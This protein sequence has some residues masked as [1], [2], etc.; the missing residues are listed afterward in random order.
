MYYVSSAVVVFALG[1]WIIYHLLIHIFYNQIDEGLL[2]EKLLIEEQLNQSS[3]VPEYYTHIGHDIRVLKYN[4]YVKPFYSLK[5]TLIN[6]PTIN[7]DM[8]FRYLHVLDNTLKNGYD[9]SIMHPINETRNMV[10]SIF[11]VMLIMLLLLL[12]ILIF[13]NYLI[14]KK[15]WLPFYET[16]R[17]IS[18]YNIRNKSLMKFNSSGISEFNLLNSVLTRM[19]AAIRKDYFNLKEFTENASHEIQTPLAIISSKLEIL[20]QSENLNSGQIES[21]QT[22]NQAVARLSKLNSGLLLISKIDNE[23][24]H[25]TDSQN[26]F[27]IIQNTVALFDDFINHKKLSVKVMANAYPKVSMNTTL[28]EILIHNLI[29]NAIK[30]N[31]SGGYINIELWDDKLEILNSGELLAD[32]PAEL[33]FRF[34]KG[35]RDSQ[36]LGLG[37]AIV[38]KICD[39]HQITIEY[40]VSGLEHCIT[41]N[42]SNKTE[43]NYG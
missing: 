7:D 15:L 8:T 34:K 18:T 25:T 33:F 6:D 5:D 38:K 42:F 26:L 3:D 19:S 22:V 20:V 28:T 2:T 11:Y 21:I 14:S 1:G 12:S 37:L 27:D 40:K 29:N 32:D 13:I 4:R 36:S 39:F 41:L 23:L 17:Q 43:Y 35:N 10:H 31:V 30:H 16:I 9:I 24:Y